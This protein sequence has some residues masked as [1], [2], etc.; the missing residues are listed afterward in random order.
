MKEE[1]IR[2]MKAGTKIGAGLGA[3]GFLVFG[4]IPGFY[5]GSYGALILLSHLTGGP[6]EATTLVRMLVVAGIMLGI[7]CAGAVSIVLGSVFGTALGYVVDVVG[8]LG[9]ARPV[10]VEAKAKN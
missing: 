7:F 8:S 2:T 5:F 9:K 1:R 4:V 3:I 6:V 10:T